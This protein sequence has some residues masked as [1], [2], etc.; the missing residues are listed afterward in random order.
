MV[1]VRVAQAFQQTRAED[2]HGGA[3]QPAVALPRYDE[4]DFGAVRF[5][6]AI[7]E[8]LDHGSGTEVLIFD[9]D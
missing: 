3:F 5:A 4:N 2:I 7:D 1:L 9:V 8:G 6:Q